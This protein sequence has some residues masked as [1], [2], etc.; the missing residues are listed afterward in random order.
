MGESSPEIPLDTLAALLLQVCFET[1]Y[2]HIVQG[3]VGLVETM[4]S[5]TVLLIL[6]SMQ[7]CFHAWQDAVPMLPS[8]GCLKTFPPFPSLQ[9]EL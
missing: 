3:K 4:D 9:R 6:L 2:Q 7:K 5:A 1:M 8:S